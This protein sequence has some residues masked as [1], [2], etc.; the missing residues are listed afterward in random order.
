MLISV[1]EACKRMVCMRRLVN[2]YACVSVYVYVYVYVFVYLCVCV[3]VCLGVYMRHAGDG[4]YTRFHKHC[5]F[6]SHKQVSVCMQCMHKQV[7]V[8]MQCMHKQVSVCMQE[9]ECACNVRKIA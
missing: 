4:M 3:C 1:Y 7:Y 9:Y 6:I 5:K 2:R 8:C